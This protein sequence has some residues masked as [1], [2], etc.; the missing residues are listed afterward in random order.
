MNRSNILSIAQ[1]LILTNNGKDIFEK[2]LG[3]IS[4]KNIE[5]PL[6][7]GDRSPSFSVK[8]NNKGIWVAKDY[9]GNQWSGDAIAFLQ[10]KYGLTFYEAIEKIKQDYGLIKKSKNYKQK[11]KKES[12]QDNNKCNYSP[13]IEYNIIPFSKEGLQYWNQYTFDKSFL[14]KNDIYQI[15]LWSI[16]KKVQKKY[17]DEITF[18]YLAKDVNKVKILRIG[19]NVPYAD[20]WRTNLP[21]TYL[22][23]YYEYA[24]KKLNDLFIAKSYKDELIFRKLGY[25]AISLQ[26]ENAK[27]LLENNVEKINNI[28][29]NKFLAL[30]A[31][32]QGWQTSYEITKKTN[33]NYFNIG[34]T[35]YKKYGL[36]DPADFVSFFNIDLLHTLIE[37]KLKKYEN[38][39][40]Y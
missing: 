14:L 4:Y 17:K 23:H 19:N 38:N 32:P 9:G 35:Y 10:E 37:L 18:L 6:R 3:K 1:I 21:N 26:S 11:I 33:W 7:S 28:S 22:W 29:K 30:G 8:Q 39:A 20:K 27:V 40:K 34:R 2:E 5:S 31:D 25:S 36:E 13:F 15:G 12:K 24:I 16:D